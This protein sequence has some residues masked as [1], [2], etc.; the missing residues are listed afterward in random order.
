MPI[1]E[2]VNFNDTYVLANKI[3]QKE[4][5]T[6]KLNSTTSD[7][8]SQIYTY[9]PKVKI[10]WSGLDDLNG[11]RLKKE[12]DNSLFFKDFTE[13]FDFS[14]NNNKATPDNYTLSQYTEG[15]LAKLASSKFFNQNTKSIQTKLANIP[16]YTI[17]NGQKEIVLSKPSN[18]LGAKT[19]KTFLDQA[20]YDQCGAFDTNVEKKQQL[21][22]FFLSRL[23]AETYLQEIARIDAEGTE[24]VGLSIHCIGLDSAYKVT[25]EHHPGIDFRFVPKFEEVKTL[26]ENK[27]SQP[28]TIVENEQ[29]QVRVRK[30]GV[31][32]VPSLGKL[33]RFITPSFSFLQ[34]NEYFKG[35]PIYIVQFSDSS[36]T[37]LSSVT[38]S[39]MNK[40]D[41]VFGRFIQII[42]QSTGF[43][44]NWVMEGSLKK[45]STSETH[46]NYVFFEKT[47]AENFIKEKKKNVASYQGGRTE[48]IKSFF[49]KPKI[50]LYNLE[51]LLEDV[52][53]KIYSNTK[54]VAS[55]SQEKL[56]EGRYNF[57]PPT[58][59]LSDLIEF[60]E[61]YQ[62]N[63]VKDFGQTLNLKFRVL[64]RFVGVFFSVK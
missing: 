25:R 60:N 8:F 12:G 34:K 29:H 33:G 30:R 18:S 51:D 46:V 10:K 20:L 48:G 49:I 53:D 35:V 3:K 38:K 36:Q 31:N 61:N 28:D 19:L 13:D 41:G 47:Q 27:I 50:F 64:K 57:V 17:L 58:E 42:E 21:G 22:L 44:Q 14:G 40:I 55:V 39:S 6:V 1:I 5:V 45:A 56:N 7:Y 16:V 32:L 52:E 2:K 63:I 26:L 24:T 62:R 9:P 59:N 43:G 15:Y 37:L 23:D 54:N 4:N 11:D